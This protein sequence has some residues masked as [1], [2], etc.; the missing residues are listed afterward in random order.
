MSQSIVSFI[1][2]LLSA[3]TNAPLYGLEHPHVRH[4]LDLVNA[5]LQEALGSNA[6]MCFDV[7]ENELVIDSMPQPYSLFLSRC[8]E[9]LASRGVGRL[10]FR[11]GVSLEELTSFIAGLS[12]P[13]EKAGHLVSSEHIKLG[14]I[15]VRVTGQQREPD[16]TQGKVSSAAS[17]SLQELTSQ[18]LAAFMEIYEAARRRRKFG[19]T[20]IFK[21]VSRFVE[22]FRKGGKPLVVL[23]ALREID[24]YSFTHSANV[25]IL[26]IA[27]A[28]ALGV[29]G[30]LLHEIGVAA[31]LHDIGK[32]FVPEEILSKKGKLTDEEFAIMRDHPVRGARY[33]LNIPG[34]P[35]LAVLTAFEHHMRYDG[36]GYPAVSGDWNINS[37]SHMTMISDIFDALCTHRSYREP[38]ER[39]TIKGIMHEKIN[40]DLHPF[41]TRNF[42]SMMAK[43]DDV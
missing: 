31:M 10:R 28:M 19:I 41:F 33:L 8:A 13:P 3:A 6:E 37:C 4:L 39:D 17:L 7:I 1:R 2:N 11:R 16:D 18:D 14:R 42:L 43:L 35:R 34:V 25:A 9:L 12:P 38:M 20:G 36:T 21:M 23:A 40:T 32:M 29:E 15:D 22:D 26:T 27:Q 24:E 5:S 30:N